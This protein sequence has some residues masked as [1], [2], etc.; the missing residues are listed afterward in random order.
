MF[1]NAGRRSGN[2]IGRGRG[3]GR[4]GGPMKA[5]PGGEC[6]CPN[7][8]HRVAHLA[9]KPCYEKKCPKCSSQMIRSNS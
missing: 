2:G 5:G 6:V 8:G 7:C 4:K 9:G 3:P 1:R